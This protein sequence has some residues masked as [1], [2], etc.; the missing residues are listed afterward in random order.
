[1]T[2][3]MQALS[4]GHST[5]NILKYLSQQNPELANT[6]SSALEAG[7]S[8]DHVIN[9]ISRNE[10][11]LGKLIPEKTQRDNPFKKI[12]SSIH[13]SLTGAAKAAAM[14]G[15]AL[16]GVYALSRAIPSILQKGTAANVAK[17]ASSVPNTSENSESLLSPITQNKTQP[18]N[19]LSN[20]QP[21]NGSQ[22]SPS[23][24][25]A[26]IQ[27]PQ[28]IEQP[29]V[30]S[31]SKEFLEKEGVLDLVK[32][33]LKRGTSPEGIAALI[34]TDFNKKAKKGKIQGKVDPEL[35]KNI[36]EYAKLPQEESINQLPKS[37][38]SVESANA[39]LKQDVELTKEAN[40]PQKIEKQST[41][42][43][44]NGVGTVKE[45]RNGQALVEVDGK[46]TKVKE[47]D[48][49]PPLYSDD[50]IADAYD[51]L[52]AKI[53]EKERS[54]FIS[55]AGYDENTNELGF[56]PRGGKYEV[57]TDISPEEAKMIKEGTGTARTS[58]E[59]REGLWVQGG[60]TRGG[61]ISQIIHDRKK[62]HK[63]DSESQLKLGIEI[64]KP[65]KQDR[66]MK[67]Q[68]DEM[69]YARN[70]S[71]AREQKAKEEER[72]RKKKEKDEAKKRKK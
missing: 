36:E 51:N 10:K 55:W 19:A 24:G 18:N 56:I 66:G 15:G 42:S 6:I 52:M 70:L 34:S 44:P 4:S 33:H 13:P 11:K 58:G 38:E 29:K 45:I 14:T 9:F 71:R 30:V 41:V 28:Q 60:E 27:Q 2:A 39:P 22:S 16:G 64:P 5:R 26:N 25:N 21:V 43:T 63:A 35:L 72:A 3:I 32:D 12:Q 67:P 47:E 20:Q 54:G 68:F 57:I 62:K 59:V 17:A 8:I 7:H 46:L 65:E 1:M 50:E 23:L 69:A 48:L 61:V 49:E 53:P 31:K 40:A 37:N